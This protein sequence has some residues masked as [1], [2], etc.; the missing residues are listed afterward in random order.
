[1]FVDRSFPGTDRSRSLDRAISMRRILIAA[2]SVALALLVIP[3]LV[4]S[5]DNSH[6]VQAPHV[7][8]AAVMIGI[9]LILLIAKA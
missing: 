5:R 6:S 2:I 1:M 3:P 9:V 4:F 7:L 8:D